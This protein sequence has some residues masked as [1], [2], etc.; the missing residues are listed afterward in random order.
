MLPVPRYW[1]RKSPTSTTIAPGMITGSKAGEMTLRPS[2][3]ESTE[4]AGVMA[5]SPKNRQAPM[6]PSSMTMRLLRSVSATRKASAISARMPP[7]PRLSARRTKKTYFTVTVR[8]SDQMIIDRM[9][10]ISQRSIPPS[11]KC[12][13]EARSA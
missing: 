6:M 13:S 5:P 11:V 9:P 7:S 12:S 3:A 4:I 10:R 8:I 2:M 1:I